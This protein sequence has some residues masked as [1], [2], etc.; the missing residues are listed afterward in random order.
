MEKVREFNNTTLYNEVIL[1]RDQVYPIEKTV[2]KISL[3]PKSWNYILYSGNF[4]Q[5]FPRSKISKSEIFYMDPRKTFLIERMIK[6]T[7]S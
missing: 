1:K 6:H 7:G 2:K 5:I 3:S 4:D